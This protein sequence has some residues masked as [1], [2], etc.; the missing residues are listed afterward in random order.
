MEEV[1]VVVC[2]VEEENYKKC[3]F[4]TLGNLSERQKYG[5][6]RAN[7]EN[8]EE[9]KSLLNISMLLIIT[10]RIPK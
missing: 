9:Y 10:I 4:N 3:L 2:C 6:S 1:N 7:I 5:K 8:D